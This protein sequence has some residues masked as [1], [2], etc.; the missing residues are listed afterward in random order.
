MRYTKLLILALASASLIG[1]V[2]INSMAG[3][4][5]A[6]P[7]IPSV[8]ISG[9]G[10][11]AAL[12][13]NQM[14]AMCVAC[15]T[16]MVFGASAGSHFVFDDAHQTNSGGGWTSAD[17][18]KT[19]IPRDAGEYFHVTRWAGNDNNFSKYGDLTNKR[20][21]TAATA[22]RVG[23]ELAVTGA[24]NANLATYEI[25]CE[26]CHNIVKNVAGG[27][28]LLDVPGDAI[29]SSNQYAESKV[30]TLCVGC[31]GWLYDS[32]AAND[33]N[34]MANGAYWDNTWNLVFEATGAAKKNSNAAEFKNDG[35]KHNINHHVMT[36]DKRDSFIAAAMIN[37]TPTAQFDSVQT[38]TMDT[39]V[40][41]ATSGYVL[42]A[43]WT[44]PFYRSS[45]ST[46]FSCYGCHMQ[47]HGGAVSTGASILRGSASGNATSGIDRINDGRG[48]KDQD[49][50]IS[51]GAATW[52]QNC[53]A[54]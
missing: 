11:G 54:N 4:N 42:K 30:A 28:N 45:V 2:A 31:H 21:A 32:N 47:G 15:H 26:S 46:N 24:T 12:P 23:Y 51:A 40:R 3:L 18:S 22:G 9:Y 41:P 52:C 50:K 10:G 16:R 5:P 34:S 35:V 49:A 38:H 53:H 13:N 29:G 1:A 43:S 8:T 25:I 44:A 14:S 7:G 20:S 27:N 37:W 19:G 39:T 17:Y 33:N 36:G 48:W 6:S